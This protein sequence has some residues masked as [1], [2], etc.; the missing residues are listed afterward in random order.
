MAVAKSQAVIFVSAIHLRHHRISAL[1]F[2]YHLTNPIQFPMNTLS[3]CISGHFRHTEATKV[4]EQGPA[5]DQMASGVAAFHDECWNVK[6]LVRRVGAAL[7]PVHPA[8]QDVAWVKRAVGKCSSGLNAKVGPWGSWLTSYHSSLFTVSAAAGVAGNGH[9]DA[10]LVGLTEAGVA[11][12]AN[13]AGGPA[14]GAATPGRAVRAPRTAEANR[15]A[16][17][18]GEG[19]GGINDVIGGG[20]GGAAASDTTAVAGAAGGA[21]SIG[22]GPKSSGDVELLTKALKGHFLFASLHRDDLAELVAATEAVELRPGQVAV[23][24]GQPGQHLLVVASGW[25]EVHPG[26]EAAAAAATVPGAAATAAEKDAAAAEK[27]EKAVADARPPHRA[28]LGPGDTFG[29][30]ALIHPG[31]STATLV[32]PPAA[33]APARVF[34]LS[35][36]Q[37]RMIVARQQARKIL[38]V[39]ETLTRV[40]LLE[41]LGEADLTSLAASVK[42]R[43]FGPGERIIGRG[44]EGK[45]M[46]ILKKG[47]VVCEVPNPSYSPPDAAPPTAPAPA[48]APAPAAPASELVLAP[49]LDLPP[50]PAAAAAAPK[51]QRNASSPAAGECSPTIQFPINA[52]GGW[53]GERA[54]L[55]NDRRAAD[56]FADKDAGCSCYTISAKTFKDVLGNSDEVLAKMDRALR[57]QSLAELGLIANLAAHETAAAAANAGDSA[58]AAVK[59]D[60]SA[61]VQGLTGALVDAFESK[62]FGPGAVIFAAGQPADAFYIVK[63]GTVSLTASASTAVAAGDAAST[64]TRTVGK[65]GCF[66][67]EALR[68]LRQGDAA[69]AAAVYGE[70]A[71]VAAGTGSGGKADAAATCFVATR[72]GLARAGVPEGWLLAPEELAAWLAAPA[73]A[74]EAAAADGDANTAATAAAVAAPPER[75]AADATAGEAAAQASVGAAA[76]ATAVDDAAAGCEGRGSDAAASHALVLTCAGGIADLEV[77]RTLGCGSFGRVKLATHKASGTVL[78]L[79]ILQKHTVVEL[80]QQRQVVREK[81]IV[82]QLQHAGVLRLFGTFQVTEHSARARAQKC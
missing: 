73:E 69:A 49:S 5:P 34:T 2:G 55:F 46:Y 42:M 27:A 58:A 8:P 59:G 3:H 68:P 40:A 82:R 64:R 23:T 36:G 24:V 76:G 26:G 17:I 4:P 80:R 35:R 13:S 54:L 75:S 67:E 30:L 74:A 51:L 31:P 43:D 22:C 7:M 57:R 1:A 38:R 45:E 79:K 50:P 20:G 6:D 44:E 28:H 12:F 61:R 11:R 25:L 52:D 77:E 32:V 72:A 41:G 78:A 70:T 9:D 14:H 29:E 10:V 15:Q 48:P 71:A 62:V 81:D 60:G 18:M 39:K 21:S 53:F 65:A 37:F 66:G 47:S 19:M 63:A 16:Q 33:A 56:V